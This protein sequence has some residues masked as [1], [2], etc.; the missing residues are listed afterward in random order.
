MP[1][2][3]ILGA[4]VVLA[5]WKAANDPKSQPPGGDTRAYA[6]GSKGERM[7]VLGPVPTPNKYDLS[8]GE[9]YDFSHPSV[10]TPTQSGP[11]LGYD[12]TKYKSP[13]VRT[14]APPAVAFPTTTIGAFRIGG[15]RTAGP[16]Q[17]A[18]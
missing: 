4:A 13:P 6:G 1:V 11:A 2:I 16:V 18:S 7:T 8:G 3:L 10:S 15:F 9:R 12:T 14:P 17:S 5:W